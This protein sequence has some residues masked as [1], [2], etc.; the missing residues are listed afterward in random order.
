MGSRG[1]CRGTRIKMIN[2]YLLL[3]TFLIVSHFPGNTQDTSERLLDEGYEKYLN[4][5]YRGAILDFTK[6]IS[7]SPDK[8][9]I[10]YLRGICQSALENK[11][12]AMSDY[13]RA[14]DINPEYAEVYYE[15]GYIYLIDQNAKLAIEQFDKAIKAKPDFAEAYVSRGTAKCMMDLKE[16]AKID[17]EKAK[18][19]GVAYSEY[20][21]C[22]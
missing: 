10:Y 17:W 13:D 18:D 15:K 16:A 5:D 19:L 21:V 11:K 12:L 7:Y 20:M 8:A 22:E 2:R 3:F 1:Y 14:L 6:A 4:E 9:E